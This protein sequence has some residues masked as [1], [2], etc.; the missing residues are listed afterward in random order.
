MSLRVIV[1]KVLIL[2]FKPRKLT[3]IKPE[4]AECQDR[5]NREALLKIA[6]A[7]IFSGGRSKSLELCTGFAMLCHSFIIPHILSL[8]SMGRSI[9][10]KFSYMYFGCFW[11][12]GF[13]THRHT[14]T[15]TEKQRLAYT[16]K[17]RCFRKPSSYAPPSSTPLFEDTPSGGY[18]RGTF[19]GRHPEQSQFL[20]HLPPSG[21]T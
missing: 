14:D 13:A 15:D 6:L 7:F 10:F 18:C 12:L 17:H 19:Q 16:P 5:F 8:I 1:K 2:F 20:P 11:Q 4:A 21:T 3:Q 9:F